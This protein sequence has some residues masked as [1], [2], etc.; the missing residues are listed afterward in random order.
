MKDLV[1]RPIPLGK[2]TRPVVHEPTATF[3]QVRAGVGRLDPVP[4][5]MRQG[6]LDHFPGMVGLP[7]NS[8][9]VFT[10]L[11]LYRV[12]RPMVPPLVTLYQ[13]GF[14]IRSAAWGP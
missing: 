5:H 14:G 11:Y 7:P 10:V 4:N 9:K 13:H 6:R 2:V 12:E 1:R 3:E 8:V